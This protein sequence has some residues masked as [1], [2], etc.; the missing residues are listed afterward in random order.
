MKT[1][2]KDETRVRRGDVSGPRD[3]G[4]RKEVNQYVTGRK[5]D[6]GVKKRA[7]MVRMEEEEEEAV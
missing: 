3:A 1:R 4:Q 2:P 6:N 7:V 5:G